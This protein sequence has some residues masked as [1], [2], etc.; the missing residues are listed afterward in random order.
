MKKYIPVRDRL[1]VTLSFI[2]KSEA[3]CVKFRTA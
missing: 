2:T 1:R 3:I